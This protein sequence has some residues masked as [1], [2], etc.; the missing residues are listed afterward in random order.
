MYI[1]TSSLAQSWLTWK[2]KIKGAS[3]YPT[4][5]CVYTQVHK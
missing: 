1:Y 4:F 3:G 2:I 5:M